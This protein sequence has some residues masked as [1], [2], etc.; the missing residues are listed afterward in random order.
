[1]TA[2]TLEVQHLPLANIPFLSDKVPKS[3]LVYI[4][5]DSGMTVKLTLEDI[6]PADGLNKALT[7]MRK[8][9]AFEQILIEYP[10]L[11]ESAERM[12]HYFTSIF[13]SSCDKP[14]LNKALLKGI[15]QF[16]EAH[17]IHY[18]NRDP[19]IKLNAFIRGCSEAF[20]EVLFCNIYGRYDHAWVQWR[21]LSEPVGGWAARYGFRNILV[22]PTHNKLSDVALN[23]AANKLLFDFF[24]F[25][26]LLMCGLEEAPSKEIRLD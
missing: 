24:D 11:K 2:N 23:A 3:E 19:A 6:L 14:L 5:D 17:R 12:A 9:A 10:S 26:D 18:D 7:S 4:E 21:P 25:S 15:E 13:P 20:H 8:K 22:V 16:N 1:M